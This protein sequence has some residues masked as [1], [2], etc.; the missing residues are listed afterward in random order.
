[1]S[2]EI[3]PLYYTD[4]GGSQWVVVEPMGRTNRHWYGPSPADYYDVY[5]REGKDWLNP[6]ANFSATH[7]SPIGSRFD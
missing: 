5:T 7:N 2:R 4:G 3:Y 1:M 6:G